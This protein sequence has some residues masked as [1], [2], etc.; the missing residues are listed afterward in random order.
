MA[1]AL[2]RADLAFLRTGKAKPFLRVD[3]S[4]SHS[5]QHRFESGM[6][7]LVEKIQYLLDMSQADPSATSW[8]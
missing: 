8:N 7:L 4:G 6:S 5:F 2:V 1:I 3:R